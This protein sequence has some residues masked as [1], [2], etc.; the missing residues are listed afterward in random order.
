MDHL[1][2]SL[3]HGDELSIAVIASGGNVG[4][5]PGST[6]TKVLDETIRAYRAETRHSGESLTIGM[7]PGVENDVM[8]VLLALCNCGHP[9]ALAK[10]D[11]LM[12]AHGLGTVYRCDLE[13]SDDVTL[14]RAPAIFN[15]GRGIISFIG[16][17]GKTKDFT[18]PARARL[19]NVDWSGGHNSNDRLGC[20]RVV[21]LAGGCECFT[22]NDPDSWFECDFGHD[23][24]VAVTGYALRHG[25]RSDHWLL[26]NWVLEATDHPPTVPGRRTWEVLSRHIRDTTLSGCYGSA[27][28]RLDKEKTVMPFRYFRIRQTGPNSHGPNSHAMYLS[29]FEL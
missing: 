2:W 11:A 12:S 3:L 7:A 6:I 17:R 24:R 8:K 18:N 14:G 9:D 22:S 23:R 15:L 1:L 25:S 4:P 26:R 5:Q 28:W 10:A 16:T 29:G 21:D 20:D 19:I 27:F 13:S